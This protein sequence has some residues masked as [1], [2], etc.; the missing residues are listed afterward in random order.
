MI[1]ADIGGFI[2]QRGERTERMTKETLFRAI[3]IH[4]DMSEAIKER[5]MI[6]NVLNNGKFDEIR[7]QYRD[8]RR[9]FLVSEE[10]ARR[11]MKERA[12]KLAEKIEAWEK[13]FKEL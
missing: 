12:M 2:V 1:T 9:G 13:E 11:L 5:D 3:E 10:D 4:N 8:S 7:L 6:L